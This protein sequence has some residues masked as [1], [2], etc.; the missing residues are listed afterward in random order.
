MKKKVL[1]LLFVL[2]LTL[3]LGFTAKAEVP[4][5]TVN[6]EVT[7]KVDGTTLVIGG[8][9]DIWG[10]DITSMDRPWQSYS[11]TITKVIIKNGVTSIG[12]YTFYGMKSLTSIET[13]DT[14]VSINENSI[15]SC[16]MLKEVYF[17]ETIKSVN[18]KCFENC[19]N[20]AIYIRP[21]GFAEEYAK[22]NGIKYFY[23]GMIYAPDGET[24]IV[25]DY[26]LENYLSTG[27]WYKD[28]SIAYVTMYSYD[29]RETEVKIVE[30][31][32]FE[33]VGWRLLSDPV[34]MY[35]LDGRET[36]INGY[37]YWYYS[38]NG[39]YATKEEI[40]FINADNAS[41]NLINE[42]NYRQA[43]AVMSEAIEEMKPYPYGYIYGDWLLAKSKNTAAMWQDS[44][45]CPIGYE[46]SYTQSYDGG[47]S[48]IVTVRNI[49]E[50]TIKGF[51]LNFKCYDENMNV[52][53]TGN[54]FYYCDNITLNPLEKKSFKWNF[55][56]KNIDSIRG[57]LITQAD[58][59]DGEVWE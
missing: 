57:I 19:P 18:G 43:I 33:N 27:L 23:G 1:A 41:N 47:S 8:R 44:I 52:I 54:S 53:N 14:V 28:K 22:S 6:L 49:S 13:G 30:V 38:E 42:K 4:Y 26:E 29:G 59:A 37:E 36:Y 24:K 10:Y 39:W 50:K 48:V 55:N 16:P 12:P 32:A 46:T 34:K 17:P 7:W 2:I 25:A 45:H 9:G 58:F 56:G 3:S 21:G 15:G 5:G 40:I 35:A 11:D 20:M 31:K 51:K